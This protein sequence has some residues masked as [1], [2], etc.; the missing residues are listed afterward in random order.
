[1]RQAGFDAI[2]QEQMVLKFIQG[3]GKIKRA[4]VMDLCHLTKDQAAKLLTRLAN[5][6]KIHK[7]GERR[8][9]YYDFNA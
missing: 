1:V 2:Q 4:D 8:G 3:H 7:H 6:S 9:A 5:K